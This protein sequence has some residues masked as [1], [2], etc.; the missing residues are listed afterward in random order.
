MSLYGLLGVQF[1]GELKNHCVLNETEP[2]CNEFL[3]KMSILNFSILLTCLPKC[4]IFPYSRHIT[5][6]SLAI[7]DTFCS[8]D[9]DSGYQCPTGMKCMKLELSRYTM[10]FNGFDEFGEYWTI[11]F[12]KCF[13]YFHYFVG[14]TMMYL[15]LQQQVS[16]L[17]IK[18]LRKKVGF[19][20]CF[21][22]GILYRVGGLRFTSPPWSSFWLGWW[23]MFSLL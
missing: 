3:F 17:Y 18:Q 10:G 1:F 11:S 7:P 23:K 4:F 16:S 19:S 9:P 14:L 12:Q 6:N 5:I 21:G 13:S 8:T 15:I 22:H 20:S 2:R